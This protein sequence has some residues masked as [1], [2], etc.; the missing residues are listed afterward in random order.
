MSSIAGPLPAAPTSSVE[1]SVLARRAFLVWV[2]LAFVLSAIRIVQF[3]ERDFAYSQAWVA[4]DFATMAR[5]FESAGIDVLRGVPV[6]NNAPLGVDPPVY[7]HWP[8]LFPMLLSGWFH[9]FGTS[10]AS[11]HGLMLLVWLLSTIALGL[12]VRQCFDFHGACAAV[13]AWMGMPAIVR[14]A[15]A[16]IHLHL[17]VL[18]MLLATLCFLSRRAPALGMLAVAA[19]VLTSWEGALLAI[20]L[21]AFAI[22]SHD[23]TARRLGLQYFA[24]GIATAAG[25]VT[26]YLAAYPKHLA[27]LVGVVMVRMRLAATHVV[28]PLVDSGS[29][30]PLTLGDIVILQSWHSWD[31]LGTLGVLALILL[32]VEGF[33]TRWRFGNGRFALVAAGWAGT[34]LI[35]YSV[36]S[37]HAAMHD[38]EAL[39]LAPLTAFAIGRLIERGMNPRQKGSAM[40]RIAMWVVV[41]PGLMLYPLVSSVV[42]PAEPDPADVALV[43]FGRELRS[44]TPAGAIV[45]TPEWSMV[46]VY[47]SERRIVRGVNSRKRLDEVL[48]ALP[49]AFSGNPPVFF[50]APEGQ[51]LESE[52]LEALADGKVSEQTT[53]GKIRVVSLRR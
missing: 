20:G 47:Y 49:K 43:S 33:Q 21:T 7:T 6:N 18:F 45:L 53:K 11:A 16:P 51:E 37:H 34:W 22:A 19:S 9:L 31:M 32:L 4:A 36:L 28:D 26:W 42:R 23:R 40:E 25:I 41:V 15:H 24:T 35:W 14:F 39:I 48:A 8:P 17:C 13:L 1:T 44:S 46:P 52:V 30:A 29:Q 27:E 3:T 12:L 10:E 38:Y 50:A 5:T 2:A